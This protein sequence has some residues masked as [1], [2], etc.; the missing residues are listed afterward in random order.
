MATLSLR[1]RN[2]KTSYPYET[3]YP[4]YVGDICEIESTPITGVQRELHPR[5]PN[6]TSHACAI[7]GRID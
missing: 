3:P 5:C 6:C 4:T 7:L 1:C 2:C